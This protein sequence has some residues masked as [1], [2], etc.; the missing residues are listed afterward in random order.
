M[1]EDTIAEWQRLTQL[2]SEMGDGELEELNFAIGDLTEVAQQVLRDEM[3]KRGLNEPHVPREESSFP[4]HSADL[5]Q[6]RN[7]DALAAGDEA[8]EGDLAHEYTWKTLLCECDESERAWQIREVLRLAGI[9]SWMESAGAQPWDGMGNPR[10]LVAA[11]RLEQARQI[12]ANPIPAAIVEQ[13]R[14]RI[15][16]YEPPVC[17]SC[18]AEEPILEGAD[19]VNVWRCETC[20]KQWTDPAEEQKDTASQ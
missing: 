20:G 1:Q 15:P 18:G 6:G 19:P 4:E 7:A 11:D 14:M 8:E 12:L 16:D 17:P 9:E 10:I 2:Y 5:Q 3:K 13:S